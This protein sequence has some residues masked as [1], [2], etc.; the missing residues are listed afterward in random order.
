MADHY[1]N[2]FDLTVHH[3]LHFVVICIQDQHM[4][5]TEFSI[6]QTGDRG[7]GELFSLIEKARDN[8]YIEEYSVF[9][10]TLDQV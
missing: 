4:G 2:I 1:V 9:Q 3:Y 6:P 7:I 8:L 10:T 5:T